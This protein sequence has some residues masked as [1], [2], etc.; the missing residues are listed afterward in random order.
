MKRTRLPWI[1][2][3]LMLVVAPILASCAPAATAVPQVVKETVVVKETAIVQQTV[4]KVVEVKVTPAPPKD[5]V[6][7]IVISFGGSDT[8]T[9]QNLALAYM[10]LHPKVNVRVELKPAE[11]YAEWINAQFAT[12]KPEISLVAANQNAD[13]L[14]AK[15]F[16]DLAPYLDKV[17]PYTG[18]PWRNDMDEGAIRNMTDPIEGRIN[19]LNLETVQVLWFYNKDIFAKVGI[20]DVPDQPTWSQFIGWCQKIKDAG[21]IPLAIEGNATSFWSMRVGWLAR[22]YV[23]QYTRSEAQLVR[24]QPGDYCFRVGIDDKWVYNPADPHNDDNNMITF[25]AVRRM[26]ALRDHV[27]T[28]DNPQWTAMYQNF[29]QLLGPMTEPGWIGVTD[30]LPLFLTQK[31]AIWLDGAWFFTSFEKQIKA[32]A[33]G[34]Y[35]A[36]TGEGTPTPTAV[37]G[38]AQA[39]VFNLGT[40]NNPSMEGPLVEA[41]ARTIEV[42]IGFWGIPK[43]DQIQNDLEVDFLMFITSPAGYAIYLSNKLDPNNLQGGINGP[44]VVK[45]VVLPS[46]YK[47]RFANVKLIGNTEKDL[48]GAYRSRGVNDY[49]PSVREWVDLAQQY[50]RCLFESIPGVDRCQL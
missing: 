29:A 38:A 21:Y 32:L 5:L 15:K 11:G 3:T 50:N 16:L 41:K 13:L 30:A 22:M 39:T 33:E 10:A 42:N 47:E 8:Q 2:F 17:S 46:P 37:P 4:E 9:W 18:S 23:D 40:F 36:T 24:C 26:I 43:K 49:Q 20:T 31:A 27:Q 6:G 12:G 48:P 14:N 28:V 19:V 44:P 35:G 7:T 25:N 34:K 1:L 45:N